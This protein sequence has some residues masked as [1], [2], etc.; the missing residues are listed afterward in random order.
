MLHGRI[1]RDA[2]VTHE[3]DRIIRP[4]PSSLWT[5]ADDCLP[6]DPRGWIE[7]SDGISE[8]R[9]V[10]DVRPK[11]SVPHPLDDLTQLGAI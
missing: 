3:E 9:Y 7:R 10:A 8:G 2:M 6:D 1:F 5:N 11:S 4:S